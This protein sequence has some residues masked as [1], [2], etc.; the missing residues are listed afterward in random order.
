LFA[1]L[2]GFATIHEALA[3]AVRREIEQGA[4]EPVGAAARVVGPAVRL[5]SGSRGNE[6][7][8]PLPSSHRASYSKLIVSP[9][10]LGTF[11]KRPT[12][13]VPPRVSSSIQI[14]AWLTP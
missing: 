4:G 5:S 1:G 10:W 2:D 8:G 9:V 13:I 7:T 14:S 11:F 12:R 6:R 3:P